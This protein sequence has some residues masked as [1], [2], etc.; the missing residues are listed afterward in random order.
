VK[1]IASLIQIKNH[2]ITYKCSFRCSD[3]RLEFRLP[4]NIFYCLCVSTGRAF[5]ALD[6]LPKAHSKVIFSHEFNFIVTKMYS[7]LTTFQNRVI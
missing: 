5:N 6:R 7:N 4:R 1:R 2:K 3:L